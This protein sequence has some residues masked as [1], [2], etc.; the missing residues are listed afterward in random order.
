MSS[1]SHVQR[2]VAWASL[3]WRGGSRLPHTARDGRAFAVALC[4]HAGGRLERLEE[5]LLKS[6]GR[7][8]QVLLSDLGSQVLYWL[9][10]GVLVAIGMVVYLLLLGLLLMTAWTTLY[11]WAG[12][13]GVL[14]PVRQGRS[15]PV[16]ELT[17]CGDMAP[18]PLGLLPCVSNR[19]QQA[20]WPFRSGTSLSRRG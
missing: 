10:M 1:T 2:V 13:G 19:A 14:C 12:E 16:Q 17:S 9:S 18:L 15:A 20:R 5:K 8:G 11:I 6:S 4:V 7:Q 3:A